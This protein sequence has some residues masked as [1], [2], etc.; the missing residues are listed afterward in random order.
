MEARVTR[1][2]RRLWDDA[3]WVTW[4]GLYLI[5][6]LYRTHAFEYVGLGF[7]FLRMEPTIAIWRADYFHYHV[8]G[9][10]AL[11]VAFLVPVRKEKREK[12]D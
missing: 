6:E 12:K 4:V 9:V 11:L 2:G 8:F 10:V 3:G 1:L 5:G 7:I